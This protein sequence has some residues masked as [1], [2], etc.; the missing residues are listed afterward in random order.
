LT[1][2][3]RD[4]LLFINNKTHAIELLKFIDNHNGVVFSAL[5]ELPFFKVEKRQNL[6]YPLKMMIN[7]GFIYKENSKMK[8]WTCYG[9]IKLYKTTVKGKQALKILDMFSNVKEKHI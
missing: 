8:G 9:D 5:Y 7:K 3:L 4:L 1:E 6:A 2:K